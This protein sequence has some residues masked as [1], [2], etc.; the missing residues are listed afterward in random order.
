[1]ERVLT[2]FVRVLRNAGV[3]VSPAETLDAAY[4]LALCG[5]DDRALLQQ[6]LAATLAKTIDDSYSL[7]RLFDYFLCFFV[8]F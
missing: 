3:R 1:M 8:C 5:Y 4:A 7:Y 6:A 2:D